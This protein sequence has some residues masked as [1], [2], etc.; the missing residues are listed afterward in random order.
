ME[1]QK[2]EIKYVFSEDEITVK[3]R[4]VAKF[5]QDIA[6]KE[7]EKKAAMAL[8]KS[9]IDEIRGNL[10]TE[11]DCVNNGFEMRTV[12]AHMSKN[13]L[14][15]EKEY[16][17]Q[18]TGDLLVKLPF[19]PKDLQR[20]LDETVD[21]VK[22]FESKSKAPK[23]E[24]ERNENGEAEAVKPEEPAEGFDRLEYNE[25]EQMF[26]VDDARFSRAG[27]EYSANWKII[28]Q[29]EKSETVRA[30]LWLFPE[31]R[32]SFADAKNEFE[33]YIMRLEESEALKAADAEVNNELTEEE[34]SEDND[35][36]TDDEGDETSEEQTG[37]PGQPAKPKRVRKK[38]VV[39]S[40][41]TPQPPTNEA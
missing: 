32:G 35:E 33:N 38:Y 11:A 5:M 3:G 19:E 34:T 17:D 13:Y 25:V 20:H 29:S 23:V 27:R 15:N 12:E 41:R 7:D 1:I 8:F 36:T 4:Q 30:F 39:K 6:R 14:T 26:H 10:N 40:K 21:D 31:F 28:C 2:V 37:Q 24:E 22:A 18:V 9:A 16:Y